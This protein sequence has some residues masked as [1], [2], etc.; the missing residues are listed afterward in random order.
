[1]FSKRNK[2]SSHNH[3]EHLM[4]LNVRSLNKSYN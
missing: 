2:I 3:D 1:M 4:Q